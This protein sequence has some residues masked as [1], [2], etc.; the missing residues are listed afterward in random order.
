MFE[1]GIDHTCLSRTLKTRDFRDNSAR[2]D[3]ARRQAF[4]QNKARKVFPD[5]LVAV[6][7][8]VVVVFH[9]TPNCIR[10]LTAYHVDE[11]DDR[12]GHISEEAFADSKAR[13][14]YFKGQTLYLEEQKLEAQRLQDMLDE[15]QTKKDEA[16][17]ELAKVQCELN[18]SQVKTAKLE[19]ANGLL[20]KKLEV[21]DNLNELLK[22]QNVVLK[23]GGSK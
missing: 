22:K 4:H 11:A 23:N 10:V 6:G 15:A 1:R 2:E 3:M 21:S 16:Q 9:E 12:L 13:E 8:K 14:A 18:K 17:N 19:E 20:H 5:A 7:P